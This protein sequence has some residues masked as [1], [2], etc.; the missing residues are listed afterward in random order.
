MGKY[1]LKRV[2][3]MFLTLFAVVTL[4]FFLIHLIPGSPLASL[5]RALPEQTRQAYYARYGLDK[6]LIEQYFIYLRNL[7]RLDL[8]ES[9]V[10]AGR[11]VTQTILETS[12]ISGTVGGIALVIG[13]SIGI[14]LGIIAAL[15]KNKLP[16]YIVM[17]IAILGSTV[18]VYVLIS[19]LQLWLGVHLGVLPVSGWG[20]PKHMVMPII[21]LAIGTVATYARYVKTSVLETLD[22]DYVL[23]A[24]AKGLSEFQVISRHVMRNSLMPVITMFGSSV[25]GVFTG[26]FVTES[27]FGIPGIGFYYIN[28]VNNRDYTMV[29]GTTVF[30]AALFI[31]MQMFL[32]IIYTLIDPRIRVSAD[33]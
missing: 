25:V 21:V 3:Y 29:L 9:L 24:R 8:G 33:K 20:E 31:I 15:Q 13:A 18:P 2:L 19:L 28:S 30:Y 11:S 14:L 4:T 1:I 16:D 27:M 6:P 10:F 7:L 23:T 17:I 32:D 5:A 12:P 22:Q 26:S